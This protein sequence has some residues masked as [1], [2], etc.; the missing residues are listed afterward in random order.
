[1]YTMSNL[2]GRTRG[3]LAIAVVLDSILAASTGW[4]YYTWRNI[5]SGYNNQIIYLLM[6]S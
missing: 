2:M 6:N 4:C 5:I 1:M 3:V